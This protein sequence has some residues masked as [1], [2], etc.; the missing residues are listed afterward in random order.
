MVQCKD[1]D[2]YA[3]GTTSKQM[4]GGTMQGPSVLTTNWWFSKI[5]L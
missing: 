1:F 2:L 3:N 4:Q 5:G